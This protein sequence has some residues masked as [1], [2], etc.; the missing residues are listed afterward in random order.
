MS[1]RVDI[2]DLRADVDAVLARIAGGEQLTIVDGE[3]ALADLTPV[4]GG[5]TLHALISD[6][7]VMPPARR[8]AI[9]APVALPDG[10]MSLS[11]ALDGVRG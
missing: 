7:R 1:R 10:G 4:A 8:A 3:R 6:G 5:R 11:E 9:L 2:A